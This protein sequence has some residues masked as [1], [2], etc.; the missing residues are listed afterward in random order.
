MRSNIRVVAA[1]A[2]SG[3]LMAT[4]ALAGPAGTEDRYEAGPV[5]AEFVSESDLYFKGSFNVTQWRS[6]MEEEV[7]LD[8]VA[9]NDGNAKI[10][11]DRMCATES[12]NALGRKT[13]YSRCTYALLDGKLKVDLDGSDVKVI[14]SAKDHPD[15]A[16]L[17]VV[18]RGTFVETVE[19]QVADTED[20][21]ARAGTMTRHRFRSGWIDTPSVCGFVLARSVADDWLEFREFEGVDAGL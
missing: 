19:N 1:I 12:E 2:V 9:D 15:C 11:V 10:S 17:N 20:N 13:S 21:R 18:Y 16:D 3:A 8:V 5:D 6:N 14:L 7:L 4:S